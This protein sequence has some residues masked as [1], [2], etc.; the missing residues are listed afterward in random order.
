MYVCAIVVILIV[1]P[2]YSNYLYSTLNLPYMIVI[3]LIKYSLSL[4]L[5]NEN[6]KAP[7]NLWVSRTK[8][9]SP[10]FLLSAILYIS[11][12]D[13]N[14][15]EGVNQIYVCRKVMVVIEFTPTRERERGKEHDPTLGLVLKYLWPR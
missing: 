2:Y 9:T 7:C 12:L 13:V 4:I 8:G 15:H 11:Q 3:E 1:L 14:T 6:E 10:P 5:P